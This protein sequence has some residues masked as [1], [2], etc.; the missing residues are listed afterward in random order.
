MGRMCHIRERLIARLRSSDEIVIAVVA[1][2]CAWKFVI[3]GKDSQGRIVFRL[4]AVSS[5]I[6]IL[7][8]TRTLLLASLAGLLSACSVTRVKWREPATLPA[9]PAQAIAPDL[10]ASA[11][12]ALYATALEHEEKCWDSCV[13]LYFE[14]AAMTCAFSEEVPSHCRIRQL[15]YSA[16]GKVISAGRRFGRFDARQGLRLEGNSDSMVIPV[17]HHG[18]VW[19]ADDF[20]VVELVGDYDTHALSKPHRSSGVGLPV[21]VEGPTGS[22][23]PFLTPRSIFPATILLNDLSRTTGAMSH[24]EFCNFRI[25]FHDPLREDEVQ[26]AGANRKLAKD[27]SAAIAYRLE[28]K[29]QSILSDFVNPVS[30]TSESRLYSL[31]P[32]QPNK[33]PVVFVHGLLS[34]P[35]TWVEM[36]NELQASQGFVENYQLWFFEYPTGQAFLKSAM[37]LRE[38]LREAHEQFDPDGADSAFS[39][40]I[41]VGH[42]MGGLISKLLVSY[43]DDHLWRSVANRPIEQVAMSQTMRVRVSQAF[44]FDPSPYVSRVIFIGTPHRGSVYA[45]R[46]VGRIGAALV[47]EPQQLRLEHNE[48]I[49]CNPGVFAKEVTRRIP[50]SIDLLDPDSQLLTAMAQLPIHERVS[51]HSMIGDGRW[52]L[53]YGA[54]DGFVPVSSAREGRESSCRFIDEKHSE[55][56]KHP[57]AVHELQGILKEHLLHL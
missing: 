27:T 51:L 5:Q 16:L 3:K 18:F 7:K 46:I 55:L 40:S 35:F 33:I 15:H 37:E 56:N 49:N 19:S 53:G 47:D 6:T 8:L 26:I 50:T 21:V 14:V 10:T 39:E 30:T 23:R 25:E 1:Y 22:V 41:L 31:E 52:T 9:F 32:Y 44:F 34:D 4:V 57:D 28:G 36:V 12:E 29:R 54:S 13:D 45:R 20:D 38:Q 24:P 42:S 43:S 11:A 2:G 17:S 48:L